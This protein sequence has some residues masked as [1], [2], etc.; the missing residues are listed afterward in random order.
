MTRIVVGVD[1][2]TG[3]GEALRW[4]AQESELREVPLVAVLAWGYLDQRHV[5]GSPAFEPDY[6]EADAAAALD[7]AIGQALPADVAAGVE[8]QTTCDLAGHALVAAVR[9]DDLLV[10][11]A[12]GLGGFRGL[13]LGSVSQHC[14][15]RAPCALAVVRS[16]A[17]GTGGSTGPG[18]GAR[19]VVVGIDGSSGGEDALRWAAEE[20][21]RRA[22]PLVV[23]HAWQPVLANAPLAIPVIDGELLEQAGA[24]LLD[25]ALADLDVAGVPVERV[26][27]CGTGAGVL[28]EVAAPDDLL[29]VGARG[30]SALAG[31]LLGSVSDQVVR[32]SHGPVVVVRPEA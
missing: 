27:L 23:V 10:V 3:S 31:L 14:L 19:R 17:S 28:L 15:H 1:G 29:V 7:D 9:P 11:G 12:R 2:S 8:R 5:G 20:A 6:N 16:S 18:T 4:A 25:R 21:R 32:H 26:L 22:V 24:E 30:R 13:L